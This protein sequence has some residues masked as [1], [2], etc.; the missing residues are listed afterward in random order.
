MSSPSAHSSRA[1]SS[2]PGVSERSS[3]QGSSGPSA[4]FA[5]RWLLARAGFALVL[6]NARYW[7]TVA[8]KVRAEL[9]R[10]RARATEI[11]DHEL[12]TLA[13][14]TLQCE[15]FAAEVA[16]TLATLTPH[17][18]R[19]AAVRAIVALEVMYDYLDGL[20]ERPAPDLIA[21][22]QMLFKAFSDALDPSAD[23]ESDYYRHCPSSD[24]GYLRELAA[25]VKDALACLPLAMAL[26][27]AMLQAASRCTEA[28]V[29]TH[30]AALTSTSEVERWARETA[31]GSGLEWREYLAGAASSVLTVHALIA[32][33]GDKHT[34]VEQAAP[35]DAV[36]LA[37]GALSTMLDSV[38]DYAED[39]ENGTL[40]YIRHYGDDRSIIGERMV[41]VAQA[42]ARRAH[43]APR[44]V[45]H[46]MTLAGVAAYYTSAPSATSEL[47]W[48]VTSRIQGELQ[49]LI[50]P[51]LAVMR[52]WRFAKRVRAHGGR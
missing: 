5:D 1:R 10:W 4:V 29:L 22:G 9:A 49:P 7:T 37:L 31:A 21:N 34:T 48:P 39:T 50:T 45:H 52:T 6:A 24:G 15:G 38:M 23:L 3:T 46:L 41:H 32:L 25:A 40:A 35:I 20:T 26:A 8:P 28:E 2:A 18:N 51:T 36:Y 17:R 27:P 47:A 44:S 42:A 19:A 43:E 30:A 16:A 33:A 11:E 12:R 14:H 13:L